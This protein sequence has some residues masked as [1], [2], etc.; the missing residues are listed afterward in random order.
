M[1]SRRRF[2]AGLSAAVSAH[3]A[4]RTV[5]DASA[6]ATPSPPLD[7]LVLG[8]GLSGLHAALL[9]EEQGAR[10]QVIEAR[11]RIGGRVWTLPKRPGFPEV[12]GNGFAV[13]YGRVL[14]RVR[15]AK[16]PLFDMTPRRAKVASW[17]ALEMVIDGVP[18]SREA[19]QRSGR[20]HQPEA[21]RALF[22]WEFGGRWVAE[23]NPLRA[24]DDWLAARNAPLDVSWRDWLL[25]R[26]LDERAI[27]TTWS[28]NPYFG[29]SAHDVSALQCLYNDAWIKTVS[30]G[31]NSLL[32][33]WGGNQQL[34]EAMAA[35][36]S[37]EVQLGREAVA[38][39]DE[40]GLVEVACRDGSRYRARRVICSLPYSVL[41]HLRID[42]R[43][44]G[45]LAEAVLTL[46]YMINT[47]VFFAPKRPWWESDGR[48]PNMWTDG[49]AGTIVAQHFGSR[50]EDVT[51]IVANPRGHAGT[52]LDRLPPA[53]AVRA[54]QREIERLRP[55]A[56]GAIEP[57]AIHSWM[58]DPYAAGDWSVFAPGQVSRFART[59][60]E[61]HGRVH[62]CGEHTA[63]ANRGME[64]A[65]ES[66]ERVALEVAETL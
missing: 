6:P 48:S 52:W 30:Q 64:G 23:N 9:L 57:V 43:P 44:R 41:R 33:I 1:T 15:E 12:G 55:A 51:M 56:R 38:L 50:D 61:P 32:S 54:V 21:F 3:A 11:D 8:A 65:L 2:L 29:S 42:P 24:A 14:D 25:T 58:H 66:A 13:G 53:E 59:M 17:T 28:T 16:L 18:I 45:A 20:N 27:E 10:V 22:P 62:F 5:A 35:R 34:P 40:G 19:W 26:G 49:L 47:L 31:S 36:L 7:V 60:A 46:P 63:R 4:T 39:R 37:S